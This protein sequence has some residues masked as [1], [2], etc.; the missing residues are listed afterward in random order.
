LL[1][2]DSIRDRSF[3]I[4]R[5]GFDRVEVTEFLQ[6]ISYRLAAR[7]G[8]REATPAVLHVVSTS[9]EDQIRAEQHERLAEEMAN[10]LHAA[11][12]S[13]VRLRTLAR[14]DADAEADAIMAAATDN[15]EMVLGQAE[16][17]AQDLL[18]QAYAS[19][20][21]L[22]V[23][24]EEA[25][26]RARADAENDRLEAAA[27]LDSARR[28]AAAL[29]RRAEERAQAIIQ[30]AKAT[31]PDRGRSSAKAAHPA[32]GGASIRPRLMAVGGRD[33]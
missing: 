24:A 5:R 8:E 11:H 13:A 10:L 16:A 25:T 28:S 19:A 29:A 26:T 32:R 9:V 20:K 4:T 6:E 17:E 31:E 22:R 3:S 2:P 21:R 1:T 7:E 12:D 27:L 18:R 14:T 15:A 30:A 33:D 23:E